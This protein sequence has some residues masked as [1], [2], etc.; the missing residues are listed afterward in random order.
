MEELSAA[1]P[2]YRFGQ[3]VQNLA[4]LAREDGDRP[5][6]DVFETAP[7]VQT[8]VSV[9]LLCFVTLSFE[10]TMN[11]LFCVPEDPSLTVLATPSDWHVDEL[12]ASVP[13]EPTP[14]MILLM[15]VE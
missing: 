13:P 15:R 1:C 9:S 5:A 6:W 14:L 11:Q 2:E 4:F 7:P 3:L 8:M 12:R 10:L